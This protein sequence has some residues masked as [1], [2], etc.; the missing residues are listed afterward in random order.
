MKYLALRSKLKKKSVRLVKQDEMADCGLACF[1]MVANFHGCATS[2]PAARK[3]VS[4]LGR[5]ASLKTLSSLAE[6]FGFTARGLQLSATDLNQIAYPLILHWNDDHFVV[7]EKF[8]KRKGLIHDPN[9]FSKWF[10]QDEI[11]SRFNGIAFEML[12][13]AQFDQS[14]NSRRNDLPYLWSHARKM[15]P[16]IIQALCLTLFLQLVA[17]ATP[18]FAQ[19]AL[20]RALPQK[21]E[22]LLQIISIGFIVFILVNGVIAFLRLSVVRKIGAVISTDIASQ[23]A[24]KLFRLPIEWFRCREVG[25]V[26]S[27]FGLVL[28]IKH[29]ISEDLPASI[30]NTILIILSLCMMFIYSASLAIIALLALACYIAT[31][32]ILLPLQKQA[33]SEMIESIGKE[34]AFLLS[35]LQ[36]MRSLRLSCREDERHRLWVAKFSTFIAAETRYKKWSNCQAAFQTTL[37]AL[38]NV[39]VLWIAVQFAIHGDFTPGMIF[40]FI[41]YMMQFLTAGF[42]LVDKYSNFKELDA[43]IGGLGE[44][45]DSKEDIAFDVKSYHNDVL[46]GNIELRDI[47]F[48]YDDDGPDVLKNVNL[49]VRAGESLAITGPSGGGKSTLAQIILGLNRP[50]SGS[51]LIDGRP[52]E[53]FGIRNYYRQ[54]AA[55]MQ[56]EGLFGGT[57]LENIT[58]FADPVEMKLVE[59]C[60]RAAAIHEEILAWPLQYKTLVGDAGMSVSSGQR[61]RI[62][63][64]R[65][66]YCRPR[67]LVL[68]EGTA[69]LDNR[70][71]KQVNE[72]ISQ[73]GITRVIFAHRKET[74]A[75]ADRV[76]ILKAGIIS[77][78]TNSS[79]ET[80][81]A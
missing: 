44:I 47:S 80:I 67:I 61:Q 42:D 41:S 26:I 51:V 22:N 9:G 78:A 63:L 1:V 74:V 72:A 36:C 50:T 15:K 29:V 48:R 54:V 7:L 31:R 46:K 32:T 12:P 24:N 20:D 10:R 68:D 66:L 5:G 40:A 13:T 14:T 37:I 23:V 70:R 35:S 27:K 11:E 53:A 56:D 75:S 57:V 43:Y 64:A 34:Q 73:L 60:S 18:Y 25:S 2:L 59:E 77:H 38:T 69:H 62:L 28:P 4:S 3:I 39:V 17:L 65:A 71:E 81:Y 6:K 30:I 55:V 49:T 33:L 21:D 16:Q 58:L 19:I 52:L 79:L 76:M 45:I 8:S